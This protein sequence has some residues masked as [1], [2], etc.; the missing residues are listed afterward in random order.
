MVQSDEEAQVLV[1]GQEIWEDWV[2]QL[3]E[4]THWGRRAKEQLR[5]MEKA[6]MRT[7]W[8]MCG[9]RGK[10]YSMTGVELGLDLGEGEPLG[11]PGCSLLCLIAL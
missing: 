8:A 1:G 11:S 3:I 7:S 2:G 9:E 6:T 4:D 10:D 5:A